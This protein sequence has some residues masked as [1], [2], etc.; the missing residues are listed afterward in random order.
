MLIKSP[1][2]ILDALFPTILSW[3]LGGFLF[4]LRAQWHVDDFTFPVTF[5]NSRG[6]EWA[7]CFGTSNLHLTTTTGLQYDL[8]QYDPHMKSEFDFFTLLSFNFTHIN[9]LN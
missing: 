5:I 1:V 2:T 4:F 9:P 3:R 6:G 7:Y 8:N